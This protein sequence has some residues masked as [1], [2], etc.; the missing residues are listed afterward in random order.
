MIHVNSDGTKHRGRRFKSN[1]LGVD[2][3]TVGSPEAIARAI[4]KA[5][6]RLVTLE[7]S[8]NTEVLEFETVVPYNSSITLQHNFSG[9]VRWYVTSWK[10]KGNP[11]P[12]SLTEVELGGSTID[13]LVLYSQVPGRAVIRVE[14]VQAGLQRDQTTR[15]LLTPGGIALAEIVIGAEATTATATYTRLGARKID[16]SLY[17]TATVAKFK[18]DLESTTHS[19]AWYARARLFDITHNVVIGSTTL[20]NSG[21][22]DRSLVNEFSATMTIGSASGNFRSDVETE[23][24]VQFQVTGTITDA[25]VQ[26]AV[27]G[28][29]RVVLS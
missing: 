8:T 3:S 6:E 21:E 10:R 5:T 13:S 18:V 1:P 25:S 2:P 20:D 19:S 11:G 24:S 14:R 9:P 4:N 17:P 27:I 28:N 7:A 15:T 22:T 23:Y 16:L 29:A 26:R 12:W